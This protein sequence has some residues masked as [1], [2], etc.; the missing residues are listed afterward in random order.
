MKYDYYKAIIGNILCVF[1][2][3]EG[4]VQIILIERKKYYA[5]ESKTGYSVTVNKTH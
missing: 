1:C 4:L 3:R 2:G 5:T